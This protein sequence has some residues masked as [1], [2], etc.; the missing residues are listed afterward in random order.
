MKSIYIILVFISIFSCNRCKN[1]EEC[2]SNIIVTNHANNS[3]VIWMTFLYPDASYYCN[4]QKKFLSVLSS[5]EYSLGQGACYEQ[6]LE[7]IPLQVFAIDL[8]V[9]AESG[10]EVIKNHPE[11]YQRY[12]FSKAQ[13]ENFDWQINITE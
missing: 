10:C 7:S 12:V 8:A 13:L 2:T 4:F 1:S 5:A 9:F 3:K 6:E 11:L